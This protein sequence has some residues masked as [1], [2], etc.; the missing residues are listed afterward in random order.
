MLPHRLLSPLNSQIRRRTEA[1][2]MSLYALDPVQREAFCFTLL[3]ATP[4]ISSPLAWR[5]CR[6]GGYAA[7]PS[8]T[9]GM[10]LLGGKTV[11]PPPGIT[12]HK[13]RYVIPIGFVEH[14]QRGAHLR[15][16]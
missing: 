14:E 10:R 1:S 5:A 2:V 3:G 13:G 6:F 9:W 8:P 7:R 4:R 15:V 11:A 16:G 12:R